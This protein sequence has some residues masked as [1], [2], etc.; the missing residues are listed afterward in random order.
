MSRQYFDDP[1]GSSR[2]RVPI[3]SYQQ[4]LNNSPRRNVPSTS[5][6]FASQSTFQPNRERNLHPPPPPPPPSPRHYREE[7]PHYDEDQN[8]TRSSSN[9]MNVSQSFFI[10]ETNL[11]YFKY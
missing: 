7:Y 5:R 2:R 9:R 1:Y 8:S 11:H 4:S 6:D 3:Q 10:D